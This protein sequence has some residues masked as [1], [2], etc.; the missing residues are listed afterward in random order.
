VRAGPASRDLP[1]R[2][3]TLSGNGNVVVD[4]AGETGPDEGLK[5]EEGE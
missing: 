3:L 4:L 5:V 1:W 2:P